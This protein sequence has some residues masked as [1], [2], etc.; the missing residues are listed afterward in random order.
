MKAGSVPAG[1]LTALALAAVVTVNVVGIWGIAVARRGLQEESVRLFRGQTEA[2]ARSSESGLA[3]TRTDLAFL[4][5][6]AAV[7]RLGSAAKPEQQWSLLATEAS[8]LVF[9]RAHPE[10]KRLAVMAGKAESQVEA[11]RRGGVPVVWRTRDE[12]ARAAAG[13]EPETWGERGIRSVIAQPG[14]AAG[15]EAPRLLAEID[16]RALLEHGGAVP[17]GLGC[18]LR[19]SGA[20][21]LLTLRA[22]GEPNGERLTAAISL[23]AEGWSAPSPW[24]LTCT[25]QAGTASAFEPLAARGRTVLVLN[26]AIMSLTMALGLFAVQQARRRERLEA[27]AREEQ[28]VR[29]LERQLFH[30]ERLGTVGRLA[31]GLAH[32]LNNPLEGMANY[33]ALAREHMAAGD[34]GAAR[35]DLDLVRQGLDRAAGIV[36]QVLAQANRADAPPAPVELSAVVRQAVD[37]VRSRPEFQGID[38]RLELPEDDLVVQGS[39]VMLGQVLLNL[40]RNACEAQPRGGE[41]SVRA[42]RSGREVEVEI[43]DRGPG[44]PEPERRRIFEPFYSTKSSTG[45]GLSVCDAIARQHHG[46]IEARERPGGGAL[47]ALHLPL[48]AVAGAHGA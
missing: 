28:R 11:A 45:L 43:A 8:L 14:A 4:A 2:R 32:E 25:Q 33:V 6:S 30:A 41:V 16:P 13:P 5:G 48:H 12:P 39:P 42:G 18:T 3:A 20:R 46:R 19:D 47:F 23:R 35:A 31:A 40:L 34:A 44:I 37:F 10:V 21:A 1:G 29:E 7:L 17:D 9:L 15:P 24:V 27:Q 22:A 38:F 36:R 26:L